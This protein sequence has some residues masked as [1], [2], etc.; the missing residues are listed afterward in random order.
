[1]LSNSMEIGVWALLALVTVFLGLILSIRKK[2]LVL[3]E[4]NKLL[5]EEL[6][7]TKIENSSL[8]ASLKSAEA[9]ENRFETIALKVLEGNQSKF[10]SRSVGKV[11]GILKPFQK[12]MKDFK[13]KVEGFNRDNR[14]N[15]VDLSRQLKYLREVNLTLNEQALDL[16]KALKGEIIAS[17]KSKTQGNVVIRKLCNTYTS[18]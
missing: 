9:M 2:N 18:D 13:E 3:K 15:Y 12:D 5:S 11:E 17:C 8:I 14:D 1:M 4:R 7:E 16:T 10:E 6:T